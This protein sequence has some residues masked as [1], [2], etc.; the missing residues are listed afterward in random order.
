LLVQKGEG[1]KGMLLQKGGE[2]E[3]ESRCRRRE[4]VEK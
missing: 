2:G 3:A 1:D 4:D